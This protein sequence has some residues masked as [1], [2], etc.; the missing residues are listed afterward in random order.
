[1]TYTTES[2]LNLISNR[3]NYNT[4]LAD[5]GPAAIIQL[6]GLGV[7]D[8]LALL[9]YASA[10]MDCS[11]T[12]AAPGAARQQLAEGLLNSFNYWHSNG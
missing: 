12:L 7:D 3:F 8:Q 6:H 2:D 4:H 10:E 11:I 5:A 1:M 9:W